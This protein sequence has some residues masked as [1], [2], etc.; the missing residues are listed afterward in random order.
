MPTREKFQSKMATPSGAVWD[1]KI[2]I[3]LDPLTTV[4]VVEPKF[5]SVKIA[6]DITGISDWTWRDWIEIGKCASVKIGGR[7]LVPVSEIQRM[8]ASGTRVR[9]TIRAK[10]FCAQSGF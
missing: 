7:L 3:H 5:V 8:C 10:L 2:K 9:E 4:Q 6:R 1:G